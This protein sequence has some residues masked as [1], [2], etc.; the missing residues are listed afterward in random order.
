MKSNKKV[1]E[2][3]D[4]AEG[5][6]NGFEDLLALSATCRFSD[7]THTNETDCAVKKAISEGILP[8]DRLNNYYRIKNEASYVSKQQ[9]KTKAIDYMKQRK[10]FQKRSDQK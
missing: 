7:C 1:F 9:N 10:L 6:D 5:F 4:S 8:E 2:I 3:I